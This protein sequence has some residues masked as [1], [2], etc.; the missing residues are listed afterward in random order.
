[1]HSSIRTVDHLGE[2]TNHSHEKDIDKIQLHRTKCSEIIKNVLAPHF[3]EVL[4]EDLKDQSYSLLIDES[5]D[6]AVQK[7]LGLI[8]IY[9]SKVHQKVVS[10]YLDLAPLQDCNAEGIVT[11]IKNTLKR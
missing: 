4:K 1:M 9:Y 6:I 7:Y 8:V 2:V 5:T 10:T 11:A 3:T